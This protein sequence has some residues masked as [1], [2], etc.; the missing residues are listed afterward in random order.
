MTPPTQ[1][2]AVHLLKRSALPA[3]LPDKLGELE[4]VGKAF[5]AMYGRE[6]TAEELGRMRM[7]VDGEW[8]CAVMPAQKMVLTTSEVGGWLGYSEAQ[9]RRLCEDGRFDGDQ[10]RGIQGAYRACV[11]AHWKV[12][13]AAVEC[14]LEASRPRVRRRA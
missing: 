1:L 5:V 7:S 11:G 9:V 10:R 2:V 14:F 12:P 6:A 8:L 13:R 4:V 3:E